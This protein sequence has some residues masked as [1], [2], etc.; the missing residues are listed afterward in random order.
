MTA[1]RRLA[2]LGDA[3]PREGPLS[4]ER[5]VEGDAE[6]E[7]VGAGVDEPGVR[8][9]GRH[10]GWRSHDLAALGERRRRALRRRRRGAP[11]VAEQI[12]A[13]EAEVGDPDAV[14]V[15]DE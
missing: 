15:A 8:L 13:R 1:P 2:Q 11:L 9:L 3:V 10:V 7:E 6:A 5:L 12:R 4:V 14:V